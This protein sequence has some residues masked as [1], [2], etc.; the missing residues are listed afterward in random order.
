MQKIKELFMREWQYILR[1]KKLLLIMCVMPAVYIFIFGYMYKDHVVNNIDTAVLDYAQTATS[2][3]IIQGLDDTDRFKV[4]EQVSSEEELQAALDNREVIAGVVIPEGLDGDIKAGKGSEVLVIVN[5]TNMLFSN[6]VVTS[7][8]EV[9]STISGGISTQM[10]GA[11]EG[12]P[13][14]TAIGQAMPLSFRTKIWYNPTFNYIN[15]LLLG[16]MGTAIQQMVFMYTAVSFAREKQLGLLRVLLE[17][18]GTISVIAAKVLAY[19]IINMFSMNIVLGICVLLYKIPFRGSLSALELLYAVFILAV[20]GLGIMLSLICENELNAT[21]YAM[22]VAVPSFLFSGFTWPAGSMHGAAWLINRVLPLTYLVNDVRDIALMGLG[23]KDIAASIY[24]LTGMA[25]VFLILSG[26][27][28][29][30]QARRKH[31]K[32]PVETQ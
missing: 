27:L 6:S 10:L 24:V 11:K 13:A 16:L 17:R 14:K 5:G 20:S 29:N 21:Q 26:I 25:A 1:N 4:V 32:Y 23:L 22:L 30:W 19:L 8:N 15:F 28:I 31:S 2:R 12:I 18:Y 3:A 7:A 9:I